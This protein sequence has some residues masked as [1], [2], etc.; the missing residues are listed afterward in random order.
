MLYLAAIHVNVTGT[1]SVTSG[2]LKL[3]GSAITARAEL[4]NISVTPGTSYTVTGDLYSPSSGYT[5][6]GVV[7]GSQTIESGGS[8][9]TP[10]PAN[11]LTFTATG[12]TITVYGSYYKNQAGDGYLTCVKL[13]GASL[14]QNNTCGAASSVASSSARSSSSTSSIRSSVSSSLNSSSVRSSASSGATTAALQMYVTTVRNIFCA[15]DFNANGID[16]DKWTLAD[17]QIGNKSGHWMKPGN[18][19]RRTVKDDTGK[20]INVAVAKMQ[21]LL[22]PEIG[23]FGYN[24]TGG[25]LISKYPLPAN[26]SYSI[27]FRN[28]IPSTTGAPGVTGF[29]NYYDSYDGD[30]GDMVNPQVYTEIDI[31]MPAHYNSAQPAPAWTELKRQLGFNDWNGCW[32]DECASYYRTS[33]NVDPYDGKFHTMAFV[34][35][36]NTRVDWYLDGT[37]M[38]SDTLHVP[39]HKAPLTIG[40]W[41]TEPQSERFG[42]QL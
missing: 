14:V 27:R 7:N 29:W 4:Q 31:E 18:V 33:S 39:S 23:P 16:G 15:D 35:R 20:N 34:W 13:S 22:N 36:S 17:M 41:G 21:G 25:G 8:S 38:Q 11:P 40:M 2:V 9:T 3:T 5:Y 12:S 32:G 19:S 10:A 1:T 24:P 37:L 42:L 26:A 28:P 6:L 30:D